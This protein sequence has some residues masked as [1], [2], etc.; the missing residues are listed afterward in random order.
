MKKLI[1]GLAM[2]SSFASFAD[3]ERNCDLDY[4]RGKVLFHE[5]QTVSS[6]GNL[7]TGEGF[8]AD[9]MSECLEKGLEYMERDEEIFKT[10]FIFTRSDGKQ[11]AGEL[12]LND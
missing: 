6:D 9:S 12:T 11:V 5:Y 10:K 2:L 4:Y 3:V 8:L 1:L 7:L